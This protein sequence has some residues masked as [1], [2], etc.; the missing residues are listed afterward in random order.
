MKAVSMTM[1]E[2]R[3]N[4]RN[5]EKHVDTH[6]AFHMFGNMWTCENPLK[7]GKVGE[8][9]KNGPKTQSP[10]LSHTVTLGNELQATL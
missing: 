5:G 6:L 4:Y 2:T 10:P 8:K 7:N 1:K 3:R 9:G